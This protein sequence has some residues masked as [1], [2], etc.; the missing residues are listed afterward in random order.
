M[1][2]LKVIIPVS[3]Y[4]LEISPIRRIFSVR[5]AA[6]NPKFL[7]MPGIGEERYSAFLGVPIIHQRDVLGVLVVQ[8]AQRTQH[9]AG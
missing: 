2:L 8:Q 9:Q 6:E 4:N 7:F 1:K 5:S 3:Q